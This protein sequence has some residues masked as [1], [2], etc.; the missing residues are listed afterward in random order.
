MIISVEHQDMSRVNNFKKG[1][2]VLEN[3]S[4][5]I[6]NNQ[7]KTNPKPPIPR[8]R[9]DPEISSNPERHRS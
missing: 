7:N 9:I 3:H 4:S 2:D 1:L 6:H 5:A 8:N